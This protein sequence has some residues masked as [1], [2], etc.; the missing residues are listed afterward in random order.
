MWRKMCFALFVT[1][2]LGAAVWGGIAS[3]TEEDPEWLV[4]KGAEAKVLKAGESE[5]LSSAITTKV[6]WVFKQVAGLGLT[7]QCTSNKFAAGFSESRLTGPRGIN[8]GPFYFEGCTAT[9]P[10]GD[11]ACEVSSTGFPKGQIRTQALGFKNDES[12]EGSSKTPYVRIRPISTR[13]GIVDIELKGGGCAN[14]GSYEVAG[15][16]VA[17]MNSPALSKAHQWA[18]QKNTGTRLTFGGQEATFSGTGEF[19]LK[20]GNEW[21]DS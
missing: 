9:A 6:N 8:L 16:L 10:A 12:L 1:C 18:F 11:V 21:G 14:P 17:K 15:L 19:T 2:A 4:K 7:V 5:A 3:A 20:S 13:E